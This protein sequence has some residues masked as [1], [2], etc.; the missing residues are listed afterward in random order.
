[1]EF[2]WL[3][4]RH[5]KMVEGPFMAR[6]SCGGGWYDWSDNVGKAGEISIVGGKGMEEC[7]SLLIGTFDDGSEILRPSTSNKIKHKRHSTTI[8]RI[9]FLGRA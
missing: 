3:V 1:M 4:L 6:Y 2:P 8:T 9:I 7:G 5:D